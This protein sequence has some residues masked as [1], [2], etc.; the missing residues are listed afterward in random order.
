[1][2]K[3][4]C[5]SLLSV[6]VLCALWQT[7]S[8]CINAPLLAPG[9]TDIARALVDLCSTKDFFA[10]LGATFLR[11]IV[12]FVIAA[13]VGF[14]LGTAGGLSKSLAQFIA[15]PLWCIKA[16]PVVALILLA[17]FWLNSNNIPI[18]VACIIALPVITESVKA[19][20][21]AVDKKLLETSHIYKLSS[22]QEVCIVRFPALLPFARQGLSTAYGLVWKAVAAGE[23]LSLPQKGMGTVL[24]L[25]QVHLQTA[26]VIAATIILVASGYV[27]QLLFTLLFTNIKI[28]SVHVPQRKTFE[29]NNA[30]SKDITTNLQRDGFSYTFTKESV[31]AI[32]APSGAGKTT[33]LNA[34]AQDQTNS[35]ELV[36]FVFQEPRLFPTLTIEQNIFIAAS[37]VLPQEKAYERTQHILDASGLRSVSN[38]LPE[39]V[40]GGERQRTSLAR[41][42]AYPAPLLLLDE[43]F[44]SQ[45]IAHECMLLQELQ[46]LL[47]EQKRTVILVTHDAREACVIAD[48][49]LV[50]QGFPLRTV[51]ELQ[52]LPKKKSAAKLYV[53]PDET[54][55]TAE[56]TIHTLL[57]NSMK[58]HDLTK[59]KSS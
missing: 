25:Q 14:L 56:E 59:S 28:H 8:T 43:A 54:I 58:G 36:S 57:L 26:H 10:S 35:N 52:L 40:S 29:T 41:A 39:H 27:S 31:T 12:A 5:L 15:I 23:V 48:K 24:S 18:F 17:L 50:M 47:S 38:R 7:V 19:G 45:D 55:I 44:Q 1:M 51:Q 32:I 4:I 21:C 30:S 11:C 42:F 46:T 34:L 6:L 16:T 9:L 13:L 37:A 2:T 53:S 3:K 49:V 22:W 20:I 33:L